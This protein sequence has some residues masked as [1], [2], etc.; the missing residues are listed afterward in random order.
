MARDL[1]GRSVEES[2]LR[3]DE[4]KF[5]LHALRKLTAFLGSIASGVDAWSCLTPAHRAA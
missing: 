4:R 2:V 3:R 5:Q 1:T